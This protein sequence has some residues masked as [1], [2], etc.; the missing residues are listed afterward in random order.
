MK[1]NYITR[2]LDDA[3]K[4]FTRTIDL[5][6]DKVIEASEIITSSLNA[7]NKLIFFGNGGSAADSQH[8]AAEFVNRFQ[9][10]RRP[11][12]ALALTTDTSVLTAI[13]ND[14]DFT[15]VFSKQIEALVKEGDVAIGISTSGTSPNVIKGLVSARMLGA[16]TIAFTGRDIS[17]TK[18]L[19]DIVLSV[20]SADTPRIQEVHIFLGHVICGL[21]EKMMFSDT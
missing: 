9:M 19:C 4:A 1:K 2:C 5:E 16:K 7:G 12:P 21:V 8:L 13:S 11:L 6:I 10:E 17:Q 14:Y 3:V 20:S 15:L 18:H